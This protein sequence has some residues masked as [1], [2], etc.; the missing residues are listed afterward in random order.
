MAR[1]RASDLLQNYAFWLIDIFPSA[2][3]PFFV[4]GGP[5]YGFNA[6]THPEVT[7]ETE[8]IKQVNDPYKVRTFLGADVGS[9]SLSRGVRYY[10]SSMYNWIDRFIEGEDVVQR[11]LLLIHN[12]GSNFGVRAEA[13]PPPIPTPDLIEVLRIPGKAW[14]LFECVPVRYKAGGDLDGSSGDVAISELEIQPTKIEE[15]SLD[16]ARIGDSFGLI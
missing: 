1:N 3:A 16:P 5:L 13:G 10:D 8:E 9:I 11:N 7:V 4:L 6:I 12:M 15:F 14:L 2:R